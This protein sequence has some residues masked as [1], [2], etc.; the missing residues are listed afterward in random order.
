MTSTTAHIDANAIAHNV[1]MVSE[2]VGES[3]ICAVVK[4]DGYGHGATRVARIAME[5]GAT[6]LA[7][8]T[9]PEAVGLA[10]VADPAGVP[11]LILSERSE[12]E[13]GS[14]WPRLPSGTRFVVA[15]AEGA[16]GIASLASP[17]RPAKVH[18]KVDTGMHRMG[19]TPTYARGLAD[20]V[21]SLPSLHL[22][23]VCSHLAVADDPSN[24]FTGVQIAR[25]DEVLAE[26]ASAGHHPAVV[27]L[28]NSAGALTL[29]G[30]HHNMVR[31]GIAMYGVAPS[32]LVAP[33]WLRPSMS[34][35]SEVTAV[36]IVESAESVS[37][38]QHWF[39]DSPSVVATVPVGYADGIRRDSGM[40]GVEML[41][42]GRRRPIVGAVT[43]DQTMLLVDESVVVGDEVTV[44]GSQGSEQIHAAEIAEKLGTIPYEV[45]VTVGARISRRLVV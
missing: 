16:R 7:V 41:V 33:S 32:S 39:A 28:A 40:A 37:Y 3:A 14:A 36:R 2:L 42:G 29:P 35:T 9:A 44:I 21:D 30:T 18:I 5:A 10:S 24:D 13:L 34:I 4:A 17:V 11:V 27:H 23:G 19:V 20:L 12:S 38:G 8:A 1:A 6:W 15:S 26:M 25:F 45:L 43:M 22:E 31:L